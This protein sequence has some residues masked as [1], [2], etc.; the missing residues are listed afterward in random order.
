MPQ[1]AAACR[2]LPHLATCLVALCEVFDWT[3]ELG[4]GLINYDKFKD[5]QSKRLNPCIEKVSLYRVASSCILVQSGAAGSAS[6]KRSCDPEQGTLQCP[7]IMSSF[8]NAHFDFAQV[9]RGPWL[10]T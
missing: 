5:S 9:I 6:S 8:S 3:G 2:I 7:C 4:K 1:L 10:D